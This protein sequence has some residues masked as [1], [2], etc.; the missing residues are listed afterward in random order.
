VLFA[1]S[2]IVTAIAHGAEAVIPALDQTA[3]RNEARQQPDQDFILAGEKNA[4]HIEGFAPF[5]PLALSR[6]ALAGLRVIYS[7]TNG[8]VALHQCRQAA[9]VYAASL[10]N[11]TATARHIA[12]HHANSDLVLACAGSI[13][14]FN[15][16][17]FLG[18]GHLIDAL[19]G[20]ES[21]VWSLT[22]SAMAAQ[23]LFRSGDWVGLMKRCRVGRMVTEMG[24]GDELE[25]CTQID[26]LNIVCQLR[27]KGIVR[28]M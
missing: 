27:E 17:D 15:I 21:R 16:E 3:A 9:T 24:L 28:V 20:S 11:G 5:A 4:E 13:G 23:T 14:R 2:T 25:Y 26:R 10:L 12:L 19:A 6:H 18:A 7:T 22:D 1:T 8:T